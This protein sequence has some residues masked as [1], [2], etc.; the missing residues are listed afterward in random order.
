MTLKA[1]PEYR[2][3]S[4]DW[5]GNIPSDWKIERFRHVFKESSEKITGAVVGPMLSV[6]GYRGIEV[7]Q[8]DSDNQR[9]EDHDLI[10]YRVV[11]VGQLVVN[12]MWLNY[13]GL[14][15]SS[16]EGHV[17]PAYRSYYIKPEVS[18]RYIHH[19]MRSSIYVGGYTKFLT[20]IRPNSLQMG[21]DDLM[22]FPIVLPP[23]IE[24]D[25]IAC[26]LDRETAKID[27]LVAEQERLIALL[28]EKRQAV[29]SHAVTKG[30]NPDAEMKDSGV[31]WLGEVPASWGVSPMKYVV[32][33][34]SGGTPSKDK[35]E[36]WGEG[37]PWASAKDLKSFELL[38][39]IDHVTH[40]AVDDEVAKL[41]PANSVLV[42]VRG[43]ILART[44]P[45][46]IVRQP[47]SINQ[48]LKALRP[49]SKLLADFLAWYLVG[50]QNES[51]SRLDEAGH[52]TKALRMDVWRSL[53]IC[54][55]PLKEQKEVC[56]YLEVTLAKID[57]LVTQSQN[58]IDLLNS[59]RSALV[60]AAVIGKIDVRGLVDTEEA[61]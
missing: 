37:F 11:R 4:I 24:Q 30:L 56:S 17:S 43:M 12:T 15:V 9:R 41:Q 16:F 22:S 45:V 32:G 55:P 18:Y 10:G 58:A 46:S 23:K 7:K 20:G 61:A 59:R 50:T 52:G 2:N 54:L 27:D 51:L 40:R 14:G 21:R 44:F 48:D 6:S 36:Y 47:T 8:Y 13:A 33:F 38:D 53:Q 29:I 34:S 25:E 39:T 5:L 60:S 1:Y 42:V 26:F 28:K 3:S 35:P 19:L 31:D 49:S 57:H